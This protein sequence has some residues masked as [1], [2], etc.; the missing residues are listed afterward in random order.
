[1]S[2]STS[3]WRS[4]AR[5][6]S[7]WLIAGT[8]GASSRTAVP[9]AFFLDR[10]PV[11]AV[12]S[13]ASRMTFASSA[14]ATVARPIARAGHS[15][16]RGLRYITSKPFLSIEPQVGVLLSPMPRNSRPDWIAIATLRI[17][18]DWMM[19]GARTT[20]RMC[21]PMIR[22]SERPATRAAST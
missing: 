5:A 6:S 7:S 9:E 21:R 10:R 13:S 20:P 18:A 3:P 17:I 11:T 19:I 4:A 1:M 15:M 8:A 14:S 22:E 12:R 2:S 16:V